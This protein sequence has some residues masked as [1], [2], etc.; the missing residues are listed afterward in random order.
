[1]ILDQ[2]LNVAFQA[3]LRHSMD[4]SVH[5]AMFD[6]SENEMCLYE[7][8]VS[9]PHSRCTV[10]GSLVL[11]AVSYMK[12][13]GFVLHARDFYVTLY[14]GLGDYALFLLH[15]SLVA[16]PVHGLVCPLRQELL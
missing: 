12:S 11:G 8:F 1:M 9:S 3:G 5:D 10:S 4:D 2:Q 16:L 7:V 14:C 13:T 6:L 15:G